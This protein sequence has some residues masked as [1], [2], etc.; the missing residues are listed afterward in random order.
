LLN[1][2]L[3]LASLEGVTRRRASRTPVEFTFA[4]RRCIS[5]TSARRKILPA[6]GSR[7]IMIVSHLAVTWRDSPITAGAAD[8]LFT[9]VRHRYSRVVL[10]YN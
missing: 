8:N 5:A 9:V 2:N 1:A 4:I 10:D 3:S 6:T 7:L